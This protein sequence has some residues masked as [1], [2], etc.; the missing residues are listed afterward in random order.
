M[1]TFPRDPAEVAERPTCLEAR[2]PSDDGT[3]AILE[4]WTHYGQRR[5]NNRVLLVRCLPCGEYVFRRCR[6]RREAIRTAREIS[7][8]VPPRRRRRRYTER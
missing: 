7:K 2:Y 3:W 6:S 8:V 5:R 4:I 1:I